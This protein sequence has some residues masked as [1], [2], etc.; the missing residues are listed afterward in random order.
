MAHAKAVRLSASIKAIGLGVVVAVTLAACAYED[1][2]DLQRLPAYQAGY[3][4]GCRTAQDRERGFATKVRRNDEV[5]GQN[6]AYRAGWR[7]GSMIC[8]PS[9]GLGRN[10]LFE[11]QQIGPA[12]L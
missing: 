7:E 6:S 8:G 5:F 1:D 12:P 11:N 4:D 3:S 10:T 9:S 2:R